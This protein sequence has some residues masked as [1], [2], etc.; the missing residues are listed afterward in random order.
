MATYT[1]DVHVDSG[2]GIRGP[3]GVAGIPV[4]APY[5]KILCLPSSP[6]RPNSGVDEDSCPQG[7]RKMTNVDEDDAPDFDQTFR[8]TV[9]EGDAEVPGVV[10]FEVWHFNSIAEDTLLGSAI[11]KLDWASRGPQGSDKF[12][13]LHNAAG[14]EAGHLKVAVDIQSSGGVPPTAGPAV[15]AGGA[16]AGAAAAGANGGSPSSS[17][18]ASNK[19]RAISSGSVDSPAGGGGGGGGGGSGGRPTRGLSTGSTFS[20]VAAD[21][22]GTFVVEFDDGP[23]GMQLLVELDDADPKES[24]SLFKV[25]SWSTRAGASVDSPSASASSPSSAAAAIAAGTAGSPS[26]GLASPSSSSSSSS[27]S[28]LSRGGSAVNQIVVDAAAGQA[29]AKGVMTGD[30]VEAIA[31]RRIGRHATVESVVESI[32]GAARPLQV[33]FRRATRSIVSFCD[34]TPEV[35]SPDC[36]RVESVASVMDRVNTEIVKQRWEV[37]H[38]E[39]VRSFPRQRGREEREFLLVPSRPPPLPSRFPFALAEWV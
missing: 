11:V 7:L 31:G 26:G 22:E 2:K 38:V 28:S 19:S 8:F 35:R 9:K 15:S 23:L 1:I 27:S 29:E 20:S 4:I 16:A 13:A 3:P 10:V 17:P 37:F 12:T 39:T 6:P 14:G 36:S 5:V 32:K 30:I 21:E 25:S 33:A 18:P 34:F 24:G